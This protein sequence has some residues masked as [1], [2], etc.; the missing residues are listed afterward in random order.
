MHARLEQVVRHVVRLDLGQRF[1]RQR[2]VGRRITQ[3]HAH[4]GF[5]R[6]RLTGQHQAR[7]LCHCATA[8]AVEEQVLGV[9]R[10]NGQQGGGGPG[11]A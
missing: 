5:L 1:A 6:Q 4:M 3:Q 8:V 9:D 7:P 11:A 2:D 10:A